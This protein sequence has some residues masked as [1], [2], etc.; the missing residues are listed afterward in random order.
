MYEN[1]N[2]HM[3]KIQDSCISCL[4]LQNTRAVFLSRY[5]RLALEADYEVSA[6]PCIINMMRDLSILIYQNCCIRLLQIFV[7]VLD[8][9]A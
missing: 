9:G 7:H 4:G 8:F 6:H 1:I 5:E 3:D 2:N